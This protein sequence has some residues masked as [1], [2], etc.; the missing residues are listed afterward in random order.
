MTQHRQRTRT[1]INTERGVWE[2]GERGRTV[3]TT[4]GPWWWWYGHAAW[5]ARPC[6]PPTLGC[7]DSFVAFRLPARFFRFWLM[8][9]LFKGMYLDR[10]P[11]HSIHHS[12]STLDF[13][14]DLRERGSGEECK[15]PMLGLRSKD[16]S[17][18]LAEHFFS[19]SSLF[20]V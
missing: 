18:I 13:S 7:F 17:T 11:P 10:T 2:A 15:E 20:P 1:R 16:S 4:T 9:S 19:F 14:L 12:P 8:F 6:V 5:H 3:P